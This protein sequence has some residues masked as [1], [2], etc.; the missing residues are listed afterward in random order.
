[1]TKFITR[2]LASACLFALALAGA[3]AAQAAYPDKPVRL[4]RGDAGRSQ[5]K[6]AEVGLVTGYG[7]MGDGAIAIMRRG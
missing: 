5:V 6:D 2:R 4:V 1:M 3:P 7:D